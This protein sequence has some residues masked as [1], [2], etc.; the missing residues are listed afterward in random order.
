MALARP[1]AICLLLALLS[2][3]VAVYL[4][5][6]ELET[7]PAHRT[8]RARATATPTIAYMFGV[9]TKAAA[10]AGGGG[11]AGAGAALVAPS[12]AGGTIA[13]AG[14]ARAHNTASQAAFLYA[15][16][17]LVRTAQPGF[18]YVVVMG[19]DRGDPW[20]DTPRGWAEVEGWF[21]RRVRGTLAERNITA[22]LHGVRVDNTLK[23]PGPV[24]NEMA[25]VAYGDP[26]R[27]DYFFRLN[28]DTEL[29]TRWARP[30]TR[31]LR[32]LGNVGV[33]G[34]DHTGGNRHILT[35]DFVHR[36]HMDIFAPSYYPPELVDWWM[37]DWISNVYGEA[38]T[39]RMERS[40][41]VHH[42][43]SQGQRYE[44][45]MRNQQ[46]LAPALEAGRTRVADYLR[47]HG[48]G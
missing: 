10:D 32:R 24:F 20:Y 8:A 43:L 6:R 7:S 36:T 22:T 23:K 15:L 40:K 1:V 26:I 5:E 4:R 13:A 45:D 37:D 12:S 48:A 29:T 31:A 11:P 9:T 39:R 46:R 25:R 41:A 27:A 14:R 38:R 16:P 44:I 42:T 2:A 17:S 34:P 47:R 35:H 18:R 3:Q 28:D 30:F 19:Y 21:E 33:V